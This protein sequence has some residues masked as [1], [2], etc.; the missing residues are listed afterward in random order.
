M[1]HYLYHFVYR[2]LKGNR[3]SSSCNNWEEWQTT[4]WENINVN[5]ESMCK[6]LSAYAW[7]NLT[8][9]TWESETTNWENLT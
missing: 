6:E 8:T 9:N 5:W 2:M 7:E 4:T 1:L 3:A